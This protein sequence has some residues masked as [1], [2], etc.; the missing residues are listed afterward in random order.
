MNIVFCALTRSCCRR[1]KRNLSTFLAWQKAFPQSRWVFVEND[2]KD[3]TRQWLEAWSARDSNVAV[4]GENTGEE[5]IPSSIPEGIFPGFSRYRIE[6]MARFRN[7]YLDWI[8]RE[9]GWD[10]VDAM[11]VLDPDVPR[12]PCKR[13]IHWL[14]NLPPR[15]AMT[16]M[17]TVWIDA[18]TKQFYDAYAY[19]SLGD[20]RP[21]TF[22][23]I[24]ERRFRLYAELCSSKELLPVRSNF[25][26]VGIYPAVPGISQC[27]Y[28]PLANN[29]SGVEVDCEHVAFH[30]QLASKGVSVMLDPQMV[31]S[32]N[33]WVSV[34]TAA[35][36]VPIKNLHRKLRARYRTKHR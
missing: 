22:E 7:M 12:L 25:N 3:K 4:I 19:R 13:V 33:G 9:I 18:V 29:G 16:A 23:S 10:K 5:T 35:V 11:V 14:K 28:A 26:G 24:M 20:M 34:A 1:L 2:S 31:T 32:F 36:R 17:G 6:R 8:S 27:R 21:Q 15:Q 30:D